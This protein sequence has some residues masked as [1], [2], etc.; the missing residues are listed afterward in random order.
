MGPAYAAGIAMG[1]YEQT[2]LF[3]SLNRTRF[4][5]EMDAETRC[6]KYTGWKESVGLVLTKQY[7]GIPNTMLNSQQSKQKNTRLFNKIVLISQR[8]WSTLVLSQNI[9]EICAEG[10]TASVLSSIYFSK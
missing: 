7:R 9:L 8:N 4:T 10:L 3:E 5:P 2:A 6:T 1:I